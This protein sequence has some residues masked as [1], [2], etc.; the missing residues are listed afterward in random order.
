[1]SWKGGSP[2][3]A[4]ASDVRRRQIGYLVL[5]LVAV[6][7]VVGRIGAAVL[8]DYYWY[9]AAGARALWWE[10]AVD[11]IALRGG[12]GLL[13]ALFVLAN[14]YAVR[15]SI[16]SLLLPRRVANVAFSEEVSPR[17]MLVGITLAS[18]VVGGLLSLVHGS[19]TDLALTRHLA[20]FGKVDDYLSRDLR[21]YVAWLPLERSSHRWAVVTLVTTTALVLGLYALTSSLG[22]KNGR[23]RLTRHVRR[24]VFVLGAVLLVLLAWGFRIERYELLLDASHGGFTMLDHMPGLSLRIVLSVFAAAAS[25][26]VLWAGWTAQTR[27]AFGIVTAVIVMTIL[28]RQVIPAAYGWMHP[29]TDPDVRDRAYRET[30]N[31]YTQQ[32]YAVDSLVLADPV[33]QYREEAEL[34]ARVPSW[35]AGALAVAIGRARA[36]GELQDVSGWEGSR[37][38][39]RLLTLERRTGPDSSALPGSWW[40]TRSDPTRVTEENRYPFSELDV[41]PLLSVLVHEGAQGYLVVTDVDSTL[42][43]PSLDEP[44]QRITHAWANQNVRLAFGDLPAQSRLISRRD[45]RERIRSLAPF[46]ESGGR[47]SIAAHGD[48]LYWIDHLYTASATYPLSRVLT[49]GDRSWS[50]FRHAATAL[51]NA[52]TGAVRL[53][54]APGGDPI[55]RTWFRRFPELFTS[56]SDVPAELVAAIPPPM[57]SARVQALALAEVGARTAPRP[58]GQVVLGTG[59]DS[60]VARFGL[61]YFVATDGVLQTTIPVIARR[62]GRV[63]GVVVARGGRDP[64]AVFEPVGDAFLRWETSIDALR[65]LSN[66]ANAQVGEGRVV[67]GAI[68]A[69]PLNG[70]LV[71]AQPYYAWP[72]SDPPRLAGVAVRDGRTAEGARLA[73]SFA[74]A[75]LAPDTAVDIGSEGD[76]DVGAV[77]RS[78][79]GVLYDS[80]RAAL[81]RGD[82]NAFGS[83]YDALGRLLGRPPG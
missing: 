11:T 81:R 70:S 63:A 3:A 27:L 73:S 75:V 46:F 18:L 2:R 30:R 78:R 71:I 69:V 55:A 43:A 58:L 59:I 17:T 48:T 83:S 21:F 57:E 52:R 40:L 26:L 14:L 20:P 25:L 6:A 44:W 45:V 22:W 64:R 39:L 28:L 23:L 82:W 49:V 53:V 67:A 37:T 9:D 80:A 24:H 15:A 29:I 34:A 10:K 5:A 72:Q 41:R 77:L 62:D 68:R 60:L 61:T 66:D 31:G 38:G 8:A 1:M 56:W 32:A 12:V 13:G 74:A 51:V 54:R 19:W 42:P 36:R 7:L 4:S 33:P 35:D 47:L 65:G 16:L 79:A 50:Y 76:D